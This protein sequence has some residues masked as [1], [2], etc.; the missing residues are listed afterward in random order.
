[1]Y[2]MPQKPLMACLSTKEPMNMVK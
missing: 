2:G 1:M